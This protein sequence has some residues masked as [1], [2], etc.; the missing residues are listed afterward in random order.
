M[1][2]YEPQPATVGAAAVVAS[3]EFADVHARAGR[4]AAGANRGTT[5]SATWSRPRTTGERLSGDELVASAILLLNAGHEAS[6]NAFGNGV[7]ALLRR[8]RLSWRWCAPAST[9]PTWSPGRSRR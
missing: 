5:W 7:V 9:T 6:V 1:Y 3:A 2:E 4:R 8:T